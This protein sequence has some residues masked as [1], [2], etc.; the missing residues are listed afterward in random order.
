[1]GT[2]T[3]VRLHAQRQHRS[4]WLYG[5][6]HE[7]GTVLLLG[8]WHASRSTA[9]VSPW[10]QTAAAHLPRF[11]GFTNA[12]GKPGLEIQNGSASTEFDFTLNGNPE[13]AWLYGHG[14]EPGTLSYFSAVARPSRS[15]A[16]VSP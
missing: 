13:P 14:H 6:G 15:T 5:H 8:G 3:E 4:A 11:G 9:A 12:D 7:S 10:L 16:A 1:M 2:L